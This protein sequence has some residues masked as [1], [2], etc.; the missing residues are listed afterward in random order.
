MKKNN[1]LLVLFISTISINYSQTSFSI[2]EAIDFS[3]N[4]NV[5]VKNALLGMES[6]SQKVKETT[7]MGLPQVSASGQFQNFLDIPITVAPANAFNPAADPDELVELQFG[8]EYN[9]TGT[10]SVNQLLFSGSYIVGLQTSKTFKAVSEY[11]K[12]KSIIETKEMVMKAYYGVLIA[13]KTVE[14]LKEIS[15]TSERIYNE[16]NAFYK[17]GLIEEENVIQLSL[18]VLNSKNALNNAERQLQNAK[19]VLKLQMGYDLSKDITLTSE[20]ESVVSSLGAEASAVESDISQ[21]ID[22]MLLNKQLELSKLNVKY[23]QSEYL[24]TLSAFFN[25]GR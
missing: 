20:F 1:L 25:L 5:N 24:P 11:Q 9:T 18:N 19:S 15:T 23:E 16:T 10:L 12:D 17:E 3:V 2:S 7:G 8:T 14:S 6:A 13:A 21:N 22:F 4:N